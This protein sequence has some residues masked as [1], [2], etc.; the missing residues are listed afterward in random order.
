VMANILLVCF[1]G[2]CILMATGLRFLLKKRND[3]LDKLARE[4]LAEENTS[5]GRKATAYSTSL[6]CHP[7]YRFQL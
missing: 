1:S 4:D 3:K 7:E 2:M 5:P 6:Q